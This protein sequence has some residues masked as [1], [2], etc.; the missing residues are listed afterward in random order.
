MHRF[1]L[2]DMH[3][4]FFENQRHR[5]YIHIYNNTHIYNALN[6]YSMH[7]YNNIHT[8]RYIYIYIYLQSHI[9]IHIHIY[10]YMHVYIHTGMHESFFENQHHREYRFLDYEYPH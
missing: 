6:I 3:E 9:Y 4:S 8:P 1:V 10:T 2:T 5:E 7:H